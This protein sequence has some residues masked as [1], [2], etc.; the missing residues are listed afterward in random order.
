[1]STDDAAS[2][3]RTFSLS[4]VPD[5]VASHVRIRIL[6]TLA[7]TTG[8]YRVPDSAVV[9]EYAAGLN[10]PLRIVLQNDQC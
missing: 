6:D 1:M 4:A 10:T 3:A 7:A 5:D 2:F 8:G 9:R